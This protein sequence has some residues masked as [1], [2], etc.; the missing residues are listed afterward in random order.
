[1]TFID[2]STSGSITAPDFVVFRNDG[3]SSN[4]TNIDDLAPLVGAGSQQQ[5]PEPASLAILGIGLAALGLAR[6]RR[7]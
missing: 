2:Y 5:A 6:R 1:M 4:F 3:A 7:G